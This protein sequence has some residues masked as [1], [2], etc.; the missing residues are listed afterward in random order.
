M[1]IA[2]TIAHAIDPPPFM[3]FLHQQAEELEVILVE[4]HG[5]LA[6]LADLVVQD[7][8]HED[9]QKVHEALDEK[10]HQ[11]HQ[12]RKILAVMESWSQFLLR[13]QV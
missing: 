3:F 8:V 2:D 9:D 11:D 10:E 4:I 7:K 1:V 13:S 12:R 6:D 5:Y